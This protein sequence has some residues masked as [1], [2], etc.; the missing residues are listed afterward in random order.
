VTERLEELAAIEGPVLVEEGL[1]TVVRTFG[2]GR[3]RASRLD[4]LLRYVP[5]RLAVT[6]PFGTHL[7]PE[8][9]LIGPDEVAAEFDWYRRTTY[10]ERP[11]EV[12]S[13][14]ELG[15][16][17]AA[18]AR[19]AHGIEPEELSLELLSHFGYGR[20]TADKV[21]HVGNI[22]TWAVQAGRLRID[23]GVAHSAD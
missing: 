9:L 23:S 12:I 11:I 7:F 2:L 4:Q 10:T 6:T 22:V 20:R 13:P 14:H 16:A 17:A 15:N 5:R 21:A 8:D 3:L 1:R 19:A 18:I